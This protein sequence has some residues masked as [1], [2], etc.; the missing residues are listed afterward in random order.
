[1]LLFYLYF[2]NFSVLLEA[3][4]LL[5]ININRSKQYDFDK[6]TCRENAFFYLYYVSEKKV[7]L[8]ECPNR[9]CS[10]YLLIS[11]VVHLLMA[12]SFSLFRMKITYLSLICLYIRNS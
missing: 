9:K 3:S 7:G 8:K 2:H 1:M 6:N 5:A 11:S 4:D 12:F 10:S